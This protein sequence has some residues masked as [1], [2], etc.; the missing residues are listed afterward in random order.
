M[1]TG[2]FVLLRKPEED[3]LDFLLAVFQDPDYRRFI[4]GDPLEREKRL[5]DQILR[6]AQ[7]LFSYDANLYA[8]VCRLKDGCR[9]GCIFFNKVSWR[10]RNATLD[11]FFLKEERATMAVMDAYVAAIE[12]AF[13]DLGL[14]KV[15]GYVYAFNER[16]VKIHKKLGVPIEQRLIEHVYRDGR[17]HDVLAFG[18]LEPEF[19][20]LT[21]KPFYKFLRGG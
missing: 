13:L 3:D 17:Y 9:V 11:V 14:H 8:I 19:R 7:G 6:A 5:K 12:Y 20:E 21:K 10:N 16:L 15:I 1:R 18:M 4:G 2:K